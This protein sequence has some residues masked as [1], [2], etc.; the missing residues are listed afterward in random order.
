MRHENPDQSGTDHVLAPEYHRST[1]SSIRQDGSDQSE[2]DHELTPENQRTSQHSIRRDSPDQSGTDHELAP[3][4]QRTST[5]SMRKDRP[6][7]SDNVYSVLNTSPD[8]SK[9]EHN[10]MSDQLE[11][12]ET[13]LSDGMIRDDETISC[14]KH[15]EVKLEFD[16]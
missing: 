8:R 5:L 2:T 11:I 3:E 4:N 1:L 10:L 16:R 14:S 6:D 12:N 13:D 7:Q 15:S 9:M